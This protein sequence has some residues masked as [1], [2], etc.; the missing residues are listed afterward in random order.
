MPHGHPNN[1]ATLPRWRCLNS[2]QLRIRFNIFSVMN[3]ML[4]RT[5]AEAGIFSLYPKKCFNRF[6]FDEKKI[7]FQKRE[8]L[9]FN[10]KLMNGRLVGR[11]SLKGHQFES[12]RNM[13]ESK[14]R[15]CYRRLADSI[16][17]TIWQTILL[18]I[19]FLWTVYLANSKKL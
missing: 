14:Q 2:F 7:L 6:F 4:R 16:L 18:K 9:D 11:W 17:S 12:L 13:L 3:R 15:H 5:D 1:S 19:S 10:D 8:K